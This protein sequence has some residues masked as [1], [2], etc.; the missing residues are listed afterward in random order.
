MKIEKSNATLN[1]A[2]LA[3]LL[4]PETT[5]LVLDNVTMT[6]N[7]DSYHFLFQAMRGHPSLREILWSNVIFQDPAVDQNSL[8]SVVLASCSELVRFKLDNV[9]ISTSALKCLNLSSSLTDVVIV[10]HEFTD[11]EVKEVAGA[12]V[13]MKSLENIEF[14][15]PY[16]S[17]KAIKSVG[18]RLSLNKNIKTVKLEEYGEIIQLDEGG[19]SRPEPTDKK[20]SSAIAA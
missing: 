18:G 8:I 20:T 13:T 11:D 1:M 3:I 6:G 19:K 4:K 15:G 10:N 17:D 5:S 7:D 9:E 16:L 12:L 2:Q 14:W